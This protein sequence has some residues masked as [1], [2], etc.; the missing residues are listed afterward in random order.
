MI[1]FDKTNFKYMS[2]FAK[3]Y[4][5]VAFQD[6]KILIIK[7]FLLELNQEVVKKK[8]FLVQDLGKISWVKF[9]RHV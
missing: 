6:I 9:Q 4:T 1:D 8:R 3:D 5:K 2:A 7:Q